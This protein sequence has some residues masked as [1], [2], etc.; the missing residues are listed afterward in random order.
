MPSRLKLATVWS[1]NKHKISGP[2][3]HTQQGDGSMVT[4]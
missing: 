2:M 4:R 3:R 1:Q